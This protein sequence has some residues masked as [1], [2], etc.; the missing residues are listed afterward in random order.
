MSSPISSFSRLSLTPK[1]EAPRT[2]RGG[3][4]GGKGKGR[5]LPEESSHSSED[6]S[7]SEDEEDSDAESVLDPPSNEHIIAL[8]H[9][10]QHNSTYAFQIADAEVHRCGIR[11][12]ESDTGLTCSCDEEGMC[13]HIQW[14]LNRL[15]RTRKDT[16]SAITQRPHAFI[17]S[18]GLRNVCDEL[19]WEL[20]E[21]PDS[22]SEEPQWKIRKDYAVTDPGHQTRGFFKERVRVVRDI[23]ATFSTFPT[24]EYRKDIFDSS[25]DF[26]V[27]KVHVPND[28]EAT[29]SRLLILNDDVF[30]QFRTLVKPDVR[31]SDYFKKMAL[32]AQD[33]CELLD[34]Y[35]DVGPA[36]GGTFDLIWCAQ[37]LTDIVNSIRVNVTERQPLR[38]S[39][40]EDAAKALVSI[41]RM[42][43]KQRNHD[44]YQNLKWPRR[45]IHGEPQI[46]RNLYQRLIGS[47]AKANP[48]GGNFVVKALQ[49]LPEARLFVEDLEEVYDLLKTVGW[50]APQAYLDKL[51]SLITQLRGSSGPSPSSS[52]GKRPAS[53]MERNV[54][55]MK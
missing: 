3:F 6:E 13:R 24:D 10:R 4:P 51:E 19:N 18:K 38:S 53:S 49:D 7:S 35:C 25:D 27:G 8:D 34:K 29:I 12:N 48:A 32:K 14:L 44:V 52:T 30:G 54:K 55:R 45:R 22:D 46:D 26:A 9:C 21:G 47:T 17:S 15:G 2:N 23:L 20:R 39:S 1:M 42:V 43:V 5:A 31:A 50:S 36:A 37:T 33:T 16:G 40:R 11:I 41:L 28:L